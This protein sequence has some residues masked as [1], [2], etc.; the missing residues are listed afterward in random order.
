MAVSY[1]H[2]PLLDQIPNLFHAALKVDSRSESEETLSVCIYSYKRSSPSSQQ[3]TTDLYHDPYE[4]TP[5]RLSLYLY[6][7]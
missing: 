1:T 5:H 7:F 3:L 6:Q 4:S 2:S